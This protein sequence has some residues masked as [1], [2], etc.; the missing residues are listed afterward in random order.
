MG[1][2]DELW[3]AGAGI[4]DAVRAHPFLT[5]LSDGTL[6]HAAFRHFVVQ[7]AHYLR[8]YARALAVLA[9]RAPTEADTVMFAQH[10]AG[11]IAAEQEMHA[12]LADALGT[13]SDADVPVAPTTTAYTSYLLATCH[14][15][16]FAEGLGAVLPCYWIYARVGEALLAD[17]SPDP[18]YA[19]WIAMYGGDE[20]QA[21][22]DAVLA[23][24]DR[25][26]PTLGDSE[27]ERVR[28]HYVTTCRYEWMFWDAAWRQEQWPV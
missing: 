18:L 23:V 25:V 1:F 7:D 17:S 21:V 14:G 11:A 5:G 9:A 24:T 19:R 12:E 13:A 15:G 6:P 26:G 3:D 22:V 20:F 8:G 27:H 10:A 4:Y 2:S 16:S 28:E